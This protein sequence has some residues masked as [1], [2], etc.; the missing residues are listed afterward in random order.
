[1]VAEKKLIQTEIGLIPEDWKVLIFN[2]LPLDGTKGELLIIKAPD[3]QLDVVIKSS[4][5]ILPIGKDL[6]K[7]GAT[8]DWLDKTDA[9]H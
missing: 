1:M 6:Y 5:F 7:V 3:L 9:I 8:Y 2:D 4:V